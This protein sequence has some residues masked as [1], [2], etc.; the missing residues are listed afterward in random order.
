MDWHTHFIYQEGSL[1]WRY[2]RGRAIEGKRAGSMSSAGRRVGIN[3]KKIAIGRI[4]WEMHNGPIPEGM[5]I[6]HSDHN[7]DNNRIENLRVV[8]RSFNKHQRDRVQKNNSLG[9]SG[10]HKE[11]N[12]SGYTTQIEIDGKTKRLGYF[13]TIEEA[14]RVYEEAKKELKAQYQY[15]QGVL[16]C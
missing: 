1:Y 10:V 11:S 3:C 16:I 7:T 5:E 14:S 4:V 8:T 15:R 12:R 13:K 9:V 2:T 6:Y